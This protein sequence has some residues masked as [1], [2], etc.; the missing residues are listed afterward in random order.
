MLRSS[1][2]PLKI[3]IDITD[4][5]KEE[6]ILTPEFRKIYHSYSDQVDE[7]VKCYRLDEIIAE[8]IRSLFERTRPRDLYDIWKLYEK[9]DKKTVEDVLNEKCKFKDIERDLE[10][11]QGRKEDYKNSWENS[12]KHQMEEIPDFDNV[13][14]Y[15][16][17][18]V[19]K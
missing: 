10:E 17:N 13:F 7:S 16:F 15:V 8:K 14:D 11:F 6:I 3:K 12:L 18:E 2:S 19:L 5:D 9:V 4:K 1:G